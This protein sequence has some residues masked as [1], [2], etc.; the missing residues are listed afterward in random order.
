MIDFLGLLCHFVDNSELIRKLKNVGIK[1]VYSWIFWCPLKNDKNPPLTLFFFI[2]INAELNLPTAGWLVLRSFESAWQDTLSVGIRTLGRVGQ[3]VWLLA[4]WH[5]PLSDKISLCKSPETGMAER[6][7]IPVAMPR[8]AAAN[9]HDPGLMSPYTRIRGGSNRPTTRSPSPPPAQLTGS[10][11]GQA[12]Q[13]LPMHQFVYWASSTN[14]NAF[15][16]PY[17]PSYLCHL[18][19]PQ[20]A[21]SFKASSFIFLDPLSAICQYHFLNLCLWVLDLPIIIIS[22]VLLCL[23][24]ILCW[25]LYVR[26]MLWF[27]K[28]CSWLPLGP[29]GTFLSHDG[30]IHPQGFKYHL[31]ANY[32]PIFRNGFAPSLQLHTAS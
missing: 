4:W 21:S 30:L 27:P 8:A 18:M 26:Q 16:F 14:I 28:N 23:F 17:F 32:S 13:T 15:L 2:I 25:L 1:E 24:I 11:W 20:T 10:P 6:P 29:L 9:H 19:V 7:E 3:S 12:C 22:Q 31:Y 5:S